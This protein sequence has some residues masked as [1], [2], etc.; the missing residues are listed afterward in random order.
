VT[1]E[2]GSANGATVNAG[3]QISIDG[4]TGEVFSG[5]IETVPPDVRT[6]Y[7]PDRDPHLGERDLAAARQR[8]LAPRRRVAIGFGARHRPLPH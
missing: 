1:H 7:H 6:K 3:E 4:F 8:R 5:H 2:R